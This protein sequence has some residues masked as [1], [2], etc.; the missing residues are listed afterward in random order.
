MEEQDEKLKKITNASEVLALQVK[1]VKENGDWK[2]E[3]ES[4]SPRET[5]ETSTLR[6]MTF[7]VDGGECL[8]MKNTISIFEELSSLN[9]E[10]LP[11]EYLIIVIRT[12]LSI[13]KQEGEAQIAG[14]QVVKRLE[15]AI[16]RLATTYE[17][18]AAMQRIINE[19]RSNMDR[20]NSENNR[21]QEADGKEMEA[22]RKEKRRTIRKNC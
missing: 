21:R 15:L 8:I 12:L 11:I 14:E 3:D 6:S 17:L 20:Q 7:T 1:K 19:L 18:L 9:L 16:S 10:E 4:G 13:C 2:M 5:E 22:L